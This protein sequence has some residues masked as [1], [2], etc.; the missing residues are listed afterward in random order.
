MGLSSAVDQWRRAH[1]AP[2]DVDLNGVVVGKWLVSEMSRG[3]VGVP[4]LFLSTAGFEGLFLAIAA[5][6]R[7]RMNGNVAQ[8]L[9]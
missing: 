7:R 6:R 3:L 1:F 9:I 8:R 4:S 2:A 5:S